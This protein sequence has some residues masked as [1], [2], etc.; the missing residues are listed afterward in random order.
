MNCDDIIIAADSESVCVM[1]YWGIGIGL[2]M[3]ESMETCQHSYR[4]GVERYV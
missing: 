1:M 3:Q 4:E 2:L